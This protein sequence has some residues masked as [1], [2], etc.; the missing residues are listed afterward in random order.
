[1]K[2][3]SFLRDGRPSFGCVTDQGVVDLGR[4]MAGQAD[5]IRQLLARGLLPVAMKLAA[6]AASHISLGDVALLPVVPNPGKILCVGL[7]YHDHV[8][9]TGRAVTTHPTIFMRTPES[10]AAH[11]EALLVPAESTQLDFEGEIAIVIGKRG[12]RIRREDAHEYVAGYACYNDGSARDWQAMTTQWTSGKNFPQTG[13][14]G[15]WMVT[16]DEIPF[17]TVLE[18]C[19]RVNGVEMQRSSTSHLIHG[20]AELLGHISTFT[21]LEPGD[22][23]VT[24]TPGGVG[25]KRKPP[26]F[27]QNGD[28]VEVEVSGV[29]ILRSRVECEVVAAYLIRHDEVFKPRT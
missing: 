5:D 20:L 22:V 16:A 9:E 8:V 14:F 7:N 29:G 26:V 13:A 23:I 10:Q 28:I 19:T 21:T 24:G 6:D 25:F 12:R 11:E 18:L 1:V 3:V 27:L 17:G 4:L 15:P 2:L